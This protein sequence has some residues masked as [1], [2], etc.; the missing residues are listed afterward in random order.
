MG[1]LIFYV[2]DGGSR[3]VD[4]SFNL[5]DCWFFILS[6]FAYLYILELIFGHYWSSCYFVIFCYLIE[7]IL[8]DLLLVFWDVL[9][10][11]FCRLSENFCREE[12]REI[13]A[14]GRLEVIYRKLIA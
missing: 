11:A 8:Y 9:L 2:Y 1:I 13:A 4:C 3:L 6:L 12:R 5:N 14:L 10:E 7:I